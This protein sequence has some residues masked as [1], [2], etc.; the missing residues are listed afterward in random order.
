MARNKEH[1]SP[2][3]AEIIAEAEKAVT[4]ITDPDLRRVAFDR[5]LQHLLQTGLPKRIV[6]RK[7]ATAQTTSARKA[8]KDSAKL[9]PKAWLQELAVEG[10]FKTPRA[11]VAIRAALDERGHILKPT[12]LTHPLASLVK[13]KILR[14]KKMAPEEGGKSQIHWH[15]W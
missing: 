4:N 15:N 2:Q 9:G 13:E 6:T 14:R 10:F 7:T 1:L 3:L 11:N 5:L 8:E 12:D